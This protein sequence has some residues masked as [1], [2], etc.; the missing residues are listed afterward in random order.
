[1]IDAA[2][3]IRAIADGLDAAVEGDNERAREYLSAGMVCLS[4]AIDEVGGADHV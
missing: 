2:N 4:E 3:A 1:M